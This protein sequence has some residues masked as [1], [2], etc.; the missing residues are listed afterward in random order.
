MRKQQENAGNSL[1]IQSVSNGKKNKIK[2]TFTN[3]KVVTI[4]EE[5]YLSFFLYPGKK[6]TEK[7]YD[8]MLS[9]S[10]KSSA[11]NYL[12]KLIEKRSY[13]PKKLIEKL[14]NVKHLDYNSALSLVNSL[15]DD[16]LI[17]EQQYAK[18]LSYELKLKGY[19]KKGV[20]S[21]LKNEGIREEIIEEVLLNF[22][23]NN[24]E[25]YNE[26]YSILVKN[27]SLSYSAITL[28]IKRMLIKK[29]YDISECESIIQ[30]AGIK[31]PEL[32]SEK[33]ELIA[34]NNEAKKQYDKIKRSSFDSF[35]KENK[36]KKALL[37]KGFNIYDIN[38]LIRKEG[39]DFD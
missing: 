34:L 8:D 37:S 22:T 27:S 30:Q 21:K 14:I 39:Y 4:T 19:S 25:I 7:E 3:G 29:S 9:I 12:I 18:D 2:L 32:L 20:Y 15:I 35:T 17:N 36:F 24:D 6:L 10:G 26:I 28:K 11:R 13:S 5:T 16:G 38:E 23:E 31:F 33:R 1:E